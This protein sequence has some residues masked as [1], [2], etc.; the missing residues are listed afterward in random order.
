MVVQIA[1][2]DCGNCVI[3]AGQLEL[4]EKVLVTLEYRPCIQ[5]FYISPPVFFFGFQSGF[6]L[7]A[8]S[9]DQEKYSHVDQSLRWMAA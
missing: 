2:P 5:E 6:S 7:L 4:G 8:L 9:Q 3:V 1:V